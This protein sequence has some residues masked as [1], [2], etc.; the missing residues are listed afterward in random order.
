MKY[1]FLFLLLMFFT[2]CNNSD[3]KPENPYISYVNSTVSTH[4]F[5]GDIEKSW[6]IEVQEVPKPNDLA[7]IDWENHPKLSGYIQFNKEGKLLKSTYYN[8][9]E[10]SNSEIK[11]NL[12]YDED[13]LLIKSVYSSIFEGVPHIGEKATLKYIYK[14]YGENKRLVQIENIDNSKDVIRYDMNE[15]I[16]SITYFDKY[17]KIMSN[18]N[19]EYEYDARGRVIRIKRN[20]RDNINAITYKGNIV[21]T[22][23][24][25]TGI[26][27]TYN[28]NNQKK[29]HRNYYSEEGSIC[30]D[31]WEQTSEVRYRYNIYGDMIEAKSTYEKEEEEEDKYHD[32]Y[33]YEYDTEKNWIVKKEYKNEKLEK[34]L[35]RKIEYHKKRYFGI[36]P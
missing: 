22:S 15:N 2:A 7:N 8:F 32:K 14:D 18:L 35:I 5:K 11:T 34:I 6:T 17:G 29:I 36:L 25:N 23:Y 10:I 3:F 33:E 19:E 9:D 4:D 26:E 1:N 24:S 21:I 28:K 13:G 12:E 16:S 30:C 31:K 20:N 27:T